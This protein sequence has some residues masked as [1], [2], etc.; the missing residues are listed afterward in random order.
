VSKLILPKSVTR[1]TRY[2]GRGAD[3]E[4][5]AMT[6]FTTIPIL[7]FLNGMPWD[8]RALNF[9]HATNPST[10]R[11]SHGEVTCDFRLRRVTV[12]LWDDGL[13]IKRIEQE[14]EVGLDGYRN[15]PDLLDGAIP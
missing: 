15:T 5:P 3:Y 10:I 12:F 8:Q 14:V 1:L 2:N 13:L 11:V 7:E 6:G 9:I 4:H